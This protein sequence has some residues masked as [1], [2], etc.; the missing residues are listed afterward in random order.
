MIPS[1]ATVLTTELEVVTE[2]SLNYA[3]N[4]DTK[5]ISGYVD[6]LEAMRQVCYKI[7]S[8]ERYQYL[9][10]SWDYG[11]ETIDLYGQ[12]PDYV[13]P[14]LEQRIKEA[15]LQDDRINSVG[16]FSFDLSKKGVIT[17]DFTVYTI[18][19]ETEISKEVAI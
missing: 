3:M 4:F 8:T 9:I 15:L 17:V 6:G 18:F 1:T 5:I 19:G 12:D 2:P 14:V 7:L 16:G 10:Y 11:I 13:C